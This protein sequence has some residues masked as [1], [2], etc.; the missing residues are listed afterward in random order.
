MPTAVNVVAVERVL[1]GSGARRAVRAIPPTTAP[2]SA[3]VIV[4][5][6]AVIDEA[7]KRI[8]LAVSSSVVPSEGAAGGED[9]RAV[10]RQDVDGTAVGPCCRPHRWP[11]RSPAPCGVSAAVGRPGDQ[12]RV[13]VDGH[14]GRRLDQL[15]GDRAGGSLADR[16]LARVGNVRRRRSV[17][18]REIELRR[19]GVDRELHGR[20]I[21]AGNVGRLVESPSNRRSR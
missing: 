11:G 15:I 9:R 16:H 6:R 4:V 21:E 14:S 17:T 20:R 19:N 13:G 3:S 18:G 8:V 1:P 12:S 5:R 7:A 2:A 10:A